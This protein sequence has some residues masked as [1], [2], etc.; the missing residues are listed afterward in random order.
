[1]IRQFNNEIV[2][3]INNSPLPIEVKRL[4]LKDILAQTTATA[5]KVIAEQL[6]EKENTNNG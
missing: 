3:V 5:E 1:M 6:K 2:G 4:V